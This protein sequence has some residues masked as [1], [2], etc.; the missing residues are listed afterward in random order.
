MQHIG[1]FIRRIIV[2]DV[3]PSVGQKALRIAHNSF[4]E[5]KAAGVVARPSSKGR[6]T[7]IYVS[8]LSRRRSGKF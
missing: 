6:S 5:F 7:N 4:P 8:M 2:P 3:V 1:A